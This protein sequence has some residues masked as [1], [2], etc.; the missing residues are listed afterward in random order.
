MSGRKD[1]NWE[2]MVS[3]DELDAVA[4]LRLKEREEKSVPIKDLESYVQ[5]G[6]EVTKELKTK[7]QI[8]K[9]KKVGN[10]FEDELWSVFYKMGFSIMN[11]DNSFRVNYSPTDPSL[12]KQIDIVAVDEETILLVECKE[13]QKDGTKADFRQDINEIIGIKNKVFSEMKKRYPKRKPKYIFA[14]K[15]YIVG[16]QDKKRLQDEN[17]TLFD[18]S[19]VKYYKALVHH[20]GKAARYQLLGTLF[21]GQ[22][23]VGMDMSIPAI[24]GKMGGISYYSFL[25]E[26]DKLLKLGYVL[27]RTNANND[28]EDLLPSYQRLIKK[29]RLQKVQKFVDSGH[30]FPNSIIISIESGKNKM[31]FN[32]TSKEYRTDSEARMGLLYLP[33]TYQSAYIIDGQHRLYGYADSDYAE[34]DTIPVVAFENLSNEDQL[35]LFM[36]INENQKSVPKSLRNILEIDI[37]YDSDDLV[38]R[39]SALLGKIAKNLGEDKKSPLHGRIIIGEDAKNDFCCITMESI[40]LALDKTSFFSKYKASGYE[41][42]KGSFQIYETLKHTSDNEKT[43]NLFYPFLIKYLSYIKSNCDSEWYDKKGYLVTNNAMMAL[44]RLLNDIVLIVM[45]QNPKYSVKNTDE[46]FDGCTKFFDLLCDTINTLSAEKRQIVAKTKGTAANEKPYR[47]IQIEMHEKDPSF[48]N[49]SIETYYVENCIDYNDEA[50]KEIRYIRNHLVTYLKG[51]F[52]EDDWY[53]EHLSEEHE[54]RLMSRITTKS[55]ENK[56]KGIT[57]DVEVWD[58]IQL[59][60]IEEIMKNGTNWTLYFKELFK[61]M[62]PDGTKLSIIT[63]LKSLSDISSKINNGTHISKTNYDKTVHSFYIFLNGEEG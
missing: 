59:S 35:R 41:L 9:E 24:R 54:K 47:T 29:D 57:V 23:I 3:G 30:F 14:V 44:I 4:R 36:E 52:T 32:E 43:V 18:D 12:T 31:Q 53:S 17:I 46:L 56:R 61:D 55:V 21:N 10:A 34:T 6:W 20:L 40:K 19:T 48:T 49:D 62:G 11:K 33:Q 22:K 63:R 39:R 25:I 50:K 60:D 7:V 51:L 16:E 13:A 26:P 27:H 2:I 5:K 15:N 58:E 28:Y 45:S 38:K 42:E 1:T 8:S 37:F